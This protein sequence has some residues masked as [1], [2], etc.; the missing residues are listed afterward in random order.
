MLAY[1]AFKSQASR[2]SKL[3]INNNSWLQGIISL[4]LLLYPGFGLAPSE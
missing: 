4:A 1:F 2:A 3:L